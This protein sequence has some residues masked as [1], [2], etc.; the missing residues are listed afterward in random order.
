MNPF[1]NNVCVHSHRVPHG[2][3]PVMVCL[4]C[5][6]QQAVKAKP[7][8]HLPDFV[9]E[10]PKPT[11]A[12]E[13]LNSA[14]IHMGARATTY[15]AKGGERSMAKTVALFNELRGAS[16][17]ETDGWLMMTLLKLVRANQGGFKSDNFEDLVAYSA[18]MGES[19]SA[20]A[21]KPKPKA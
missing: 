14:E 9:F 12:Q 18:L 6:S 5:G 8:A 15:D 3:K 19:A 1:A 10:L 21:R 20:E 7:T 13:F 16:L 17:T 2:S 4:D 11:T